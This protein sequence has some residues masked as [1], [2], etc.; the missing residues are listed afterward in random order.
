MIYGYLASGI[1]NSLSAKQ[2]A[3]AQKEIA[4]YTASEMR[5]RIELQSRM[6]SK[7]DWGFVGNVSSQGFLLIEAYEKY[8]SVYEDGK[9][10][11][12]ESFIGIRETP[13][14]PLMS[15]LSVPDFRIVYQGKTNIPQV[16]A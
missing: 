5:H 2:A 9:K 10:R 12:G 13:R 1:A 16:N 4:A 3:K 6:F 8:R 15:Q 7:Q 11:Y 14:H